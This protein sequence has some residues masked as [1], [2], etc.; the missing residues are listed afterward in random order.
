VEYE[1]GTNPERVEHVR[2]GM[3]QALVVDPNDLGGRAGWICQGTE[4]IEN[5]ANAQLFADGSNRP[6]CRVQFQ[7]K[8]EANPHVVNAIGH[9]DRRQVEV[10]A[11]G[12]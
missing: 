9:L 12:F 6:H 10:N 7:G 2:H 11:E 3:C 4:D 8:Q 5:R 1:S